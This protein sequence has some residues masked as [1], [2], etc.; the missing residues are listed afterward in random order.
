MSLFGTLAGAFWLLMFSATQLGW[1]TVA[2]KPLGWIGIVVVVIWVIDAFIV[3]FSG[4]ILAKRG[5]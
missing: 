4:A 1:W 5:Q 2:P 3:R